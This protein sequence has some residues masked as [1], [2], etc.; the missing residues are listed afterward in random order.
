MFLI[1][2]KKGIRVVT[3]PYSERTGYNPPR[4]VA[5]VVT[6]SHHHY[7]HDNVAAVEGSPRIIEGIGITNYQSI[8]IEGISS[9]HDEVNGEKRGSNTIFKFIIDG[10]TIA[11]MGDFGQPI[12]QE[13]ISALQGVNVLLIPVGGTYTIDAAEAA[14]DVG[15]IKPNIVIPMHYKTKD[16]NIKVEGVGPFLKRMTKIENKGSSITL[17]PSSIPE[18]TEVWVMEYM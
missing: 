6:I 4:L 13:Q 16:C 18:E 11:H 15:K 1:E 7:D 2:D 5:D 12:T 10:L 17:T 9:Y 8:S 3:D 14:E